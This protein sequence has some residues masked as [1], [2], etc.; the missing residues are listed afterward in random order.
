MDIDTADN[1]SR[2]SS[3]RDTCS[4]NVVHKIELRT[5]ILEV[6]K[7]NLPLCLVEVD[8]R[9]QEVNARAQEVNARAQ[10]HLQETQTL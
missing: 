7:V 10:V 4:A 1:T 6:I 5:Q 3:N 8:T 9:A 2:N